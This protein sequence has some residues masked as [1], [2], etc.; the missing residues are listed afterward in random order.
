M[1]KRDYYEVLGVSRNAAEA[2]L[3][4]AYRQLAR[5]YHPDV[6]PGDKG[7]EEKFK[8]ISEAYAVLSDP[9]QRKK[10]DI[11]GHEAFG[12]G[13]DP[14]EGFRTGARGFGDFEDVL[15]GI[16]GGSRRASSRGGFG[17]IFSDIFGGAREQPPPRPQN[18]RGNDIN[19]TL[20]VTLDDAFQG[21][22]VSISL[23]RNQGNGKIA[24]ERLRVRI[25]KGVDN[26]S[27]VRLAG[28]GEPGHNGG[29]P[30][31]LYIVVKVR[32]HPVF[33]RKGDNLYET[34][35]ITFA[36]AVLGNRVIVP[37]MEG[38]TKMTVPEGTQSD[39]TFRLKGK[40]MPHLKGGGQGD[41]YVKVNIVV[42]KNLN[43]D[44]RALIRE[45]DRMNPANPRNEKVG[46]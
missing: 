43:D 5:K 33:E 4:K 1:V 6:N 32:P 30:G 20:E 17:D 34:V 22:L 37:T 25:P 38:E 9:E 29:P 46:S 35:P 2:E 12:P 19:Y 3:K 41:L 39:Q 8:E 24:P 7:A 42:P 26:G 13:F 11:M 36:E 10:Y 21:R 23:N 44:S 18:L 15:R 31:D 45:F 40:G 16:F 14:F 27:K 28:K